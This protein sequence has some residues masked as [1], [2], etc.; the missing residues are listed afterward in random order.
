[1]KGIIILCKNICPN[2]E[3]ANPICESCLI[4]DKLSY[5]Q[6]KTK[7]SNRCSTSCSSM[8][9]QAQ[10]Y[11]PHLGQPSWCIIKEKRGVIC[12]LGP[13]HQ[14]LWSIC[15]ILSW[16]S[17]TMGR[18]TILASL[19]QSL[20]IPGNQWLLYKTSLPTI[21]W[22]KGV[23]WA[24]GLVVPVVTPRHCLKQLEYLKMCNL[25]LDFFQSATRT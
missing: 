15:S 1:M 17:Q 9:W 22:I 13:Q 25:F 5:I 14:M 6:E 12:W 21:S 3:I 7:L 10:G 2:V 24:N 19:G 18:A 20:P 23:F 16:V 11:Q 4:S 8:S